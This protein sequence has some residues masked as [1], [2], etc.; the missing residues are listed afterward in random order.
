MGSNVTLREMYIVDVGMGSMCGHQ[1]VSYLGRL[2]SKGVLQTS[3]LV[4]EGS[5][6][7]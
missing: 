7:Y 5:C 2:L 1:G 6:F 4:A 3:A